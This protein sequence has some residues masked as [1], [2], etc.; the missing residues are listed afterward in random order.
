MS[1]SSNFS[2]DQMPKK[3]PN[4]SKIARE[5]DVSRETLNSRIKKAKS[6]PTP[7]DSHRNNLRAF[8]EKALI[9]WIVK[10]HSWNLPPTAAVIEA[11]ANQALSRAGQEKQVSKMWAYRFIERLPKHLQLAPVK[12]KTKELK[13]IQAEDA[14]FLAHWYDQLEFL[15]R[16]VPARLVYNFDE[17]GFQPGQG[18]SRN[19]IGSSSSCPNLAESERGENITAV[20]CI[21]ADGWLMDPLFIF[22]STG[23]FMEA[24][25]D[26]SDNLPL[27]SAA[28]ISQNGWITDELAL[29]W[30]DHFIAATA[31]SDRLKSGEKRYLLFDGHGAHLTLEFLQKCEQNSI[32]PFAFLPHSTHIYQ[33]LDGKPFLNYKQQFRLMN[34]ELSF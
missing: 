1:K 23:N 28:A 21:A 2:E 30:L 32:I 24:W 22:K 17:C 27:N 9:N 14:G 18:R 3:K 13:R 5:F 34:N 6:S 19:V 8:Q 16:D 29:A 10:M 15:L 12:Q 7:K 11:W 33:P 25:F 31:T 26:G 4:I 20:E